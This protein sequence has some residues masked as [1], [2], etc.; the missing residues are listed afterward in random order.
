[1][2]TQILSIHAQHIFPVVRITRN[3]VYNGKTIPQMTHY[4]NCSIAAA[5][6]KYAE[7]DMFD[8]SMVREIT[9]LSN[10]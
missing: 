5:L 9:I 7:K 4:N 3:T 10:D 8:L 6:F 1:M 2:E